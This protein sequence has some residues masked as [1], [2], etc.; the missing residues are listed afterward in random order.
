MVLGVLRMVRV[1]RMVGAMHVLL[2]ATLVAM[3][4]VMVMVPVLAV[5]MFVAVM[6]LAMMDVFRRARV[7]RHHRARPAA[8]LTRCRH[9]SLSFLCAMRW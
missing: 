9:R 4:M 1:D 5:G 2:L 6:P 7:H 8:W 3:A